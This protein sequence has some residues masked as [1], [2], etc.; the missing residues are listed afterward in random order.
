MCGSNPGF[1]IV[2]QIASLP[3]WF[4]GAWRHHNAVQQACARAMRWEAIKSNIHG[5]I[6]TWSRIFASCPLFS[7]RG[8][9][10]SEF[11]AQEKVATI[12][13]IDLY[14]QLETILEFTTTYLLVRH[15][16]MRRCKQ[17]NSSYCIASKFDLATLSEEKINLNCVY[18]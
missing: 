17:H 5:N 2:N 12:N 13:I 3:N 8:Y 10:F 6:P 15:M 16:D 1:R 9:F 7:G 14:V 11:R 18:M 4:T